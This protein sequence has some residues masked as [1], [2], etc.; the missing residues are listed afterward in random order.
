M[1]II[2]E[3]NAVATII[4]AN[5]G[6]SIGKFGI[7]LKKINNGELILHDGHKYCIEQLRL[8]GVEIVILEFFNLTELY[9]PVD[10][11][12]EADIID[13]TSVLNL[14]IL[15]NLDVDYIIYNAND[16]V[17][18]DAGTIQLVDDRLATEDYK[19]KLKMSDFYYSLFR[20]NLFLL[21]QRNNEEI[22]TVRSH[23]GGPDIFALNHYF[24][25]Y[26]SCKILIVHPVMFEGEQIPLTNAVT[27]EEIHDD[28]KTFLNYFYQ[29]PKDTI[30]NDPGGVEAAVEQAA[31]DLG[32]TIENFIIIDDATFVG[33]DKL[34][35]SVEFKGA[36]NTTFPANR[37]L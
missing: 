27:L 10:M 34:F 30:V 4:A 25:K 28:T 17:T 31:T 11:G 35:I 7:N 6:K 2:H 15:E 29:I 18:F 26:T 20:N 12:Q 33:A 13:Q 16:Y 3:D 24:N 37:W 1:E 22:T 8:D 21:T 14:C 36:Y 5:P 32:H 19:N 9:K 23:K